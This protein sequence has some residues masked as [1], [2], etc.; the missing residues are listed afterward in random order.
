MWDGG[1]N[2]HVRKR[3]IALRQPWTALNQAS[4][5]RS[6]IPLLK[7]QEV[8]NKTLKQFLDIVKSLIRYDCFVG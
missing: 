3:Q 6:T 8:W 5:Y 7:K 4:P 1:A 2:E